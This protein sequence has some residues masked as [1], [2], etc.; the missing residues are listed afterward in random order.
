MN[1][2]NTI[3]Y[4]STVKHPHNRGMLKQRCYESIYESILPFSN[5]K[6]ET[7]CESALSF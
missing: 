1:T 7:T 6:D 4:F 3:T 2:I 5:L